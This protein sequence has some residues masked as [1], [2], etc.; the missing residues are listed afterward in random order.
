MDSCASIFD[1][2]GPR[3]GNMYDYVLNDEIGYILVD[4]GL[5]GVNYN[6]LAAFHTNFHDA[7]FTALAAGVTNPNLDQGNI[8]PYSCGGGSN[9]YNVI[10]VGKHFSWAF[11]AYFESDGDR[12][13]VHVWNFLTIGIWTYG[14]R[15]WRMQDTTMTAASMHYDLGNVYVDHMTNINNLN[16]NGYMSTGVF[17]GGMSADKASYLTNVVDGNEHNYDGVLDSVHQ[18]NFGSAGHNTLIESAERWY[19]NY[20]AITAVFSDTIFCRPLP[21]ATGYNKLVGL[22]VNTYSVTTTD[23]YNN[24]FGVLTIGAVGNT[25]I[26]NPNFIRHKYPHVPIYQ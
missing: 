9:F 12:A 26:P 24:P 7:V 15:D 8:Y 17:Y 23:I 22:G 6:P 5:A 19:S 18:V 1:Y 14:Q 20:A 13:D 2:N 10:Y 21:S 16:G 4:S 3:S 25:V 11:R